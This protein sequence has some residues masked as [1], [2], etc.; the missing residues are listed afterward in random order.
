MA[1]FDRAGPRWTLCGEETLHVGDEIAILSEHTAHHPDAYG[2]II[3]S[4]HRSGL[5]IVLLFVGSATLGQV[6]LPLGD[7][8]GRRVRGAAVVGGI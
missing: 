1:P 4:D 7:I 3:A 5:P 6:A 2:R 8:L